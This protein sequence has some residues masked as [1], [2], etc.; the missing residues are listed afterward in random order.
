MRIPYFILRGESMEAYLLVDFGSTYT[1][2]T[3]VDLEKC[4]IIASSKDITTINEGIMIGYKRA[5][6]K[7]KESFKQDIKFEKILAC[8]SAAG[9]LK[10]ISIGLGR[11]LTVEAAKRAALGAGARILGSYSYE[12][13]EEKLDEIENLDCDIIL[14]SGGTNGGNSRNILY[15]AEKLAQRKLKIPIVVAGNEKVQDEIK[16]IFEKSNMEYYITENVMPKVNVLNANPARKTI[17]SIFMDRIVYAKGIDKF[18]GEIDGVLM[19]TPAAVLKGAELLSKGSENESGIGDLIVVDVG[20]ATTDIHSIAQGSVVDLETRFEGLQEPFSKRTVEGDLGMRYSALSLYEAVGEEKIK[21]YL[22]DKADIY[23]L[24]KFRSQNIRMVPKSDFDYKT[25]EAIAKSA[26]ELAVKRHCGKLRKEFSYS[27]YIYYQSGKDLRS[28]KNIIGT[29]GVIVHSK[30]PKEIL[31]ALEENKE[32]PLLLT[33]QSPDYFVDKEYILSAMGLLGMI[34]PDESIK[35][36][37]KYL[38]KLEL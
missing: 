18:K 22:K 4:E 10:M 19:P 38:K 2:I 35:I 17:R 6:E 16:N 23:D 36:M 29:G 7:L 32:D 14:L 37:K 30:N 33:P 27:R 25:D 11:D 28:V 13:T 8:S 20:G 21:Y 9:G 34:K 15:N 26:V 31:K 24:C 1:K 3:C 5:M 12:L